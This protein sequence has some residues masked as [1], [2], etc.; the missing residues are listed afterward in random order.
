MI[1]FCEKNPQ[2]GQKIMMTFFK[3]MEPRNYEVKN[4]DPTEPI[5]I[6]HWYPIEG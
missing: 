3:G 6:T 1:N 4:Y 5:M 2:V